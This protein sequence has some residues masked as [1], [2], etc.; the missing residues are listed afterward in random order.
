MMK[1]SKPSTLERYTNIFFVFTLSGILHVLFD[2]AV[3]KVDSKISTML[4][5][6]SFAFGV[7]IEDGVQ[8]L[9]RRLKGQKFHSQC[10]VS[11]WK[12]ILG[13]LWVAMFIIIVAPWFAYPTARVPAELM[14]FGPVT[15]TERLGIQI[16]AI[17]ISIGAIPLWL[18]FKAKP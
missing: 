15:V 4:F 2:I 16:T 9:W 10:D 11:L 3:G 18:V 6:Q 5:F 7:M 12:R 1:L 13:F 14:A 17:V 8:A